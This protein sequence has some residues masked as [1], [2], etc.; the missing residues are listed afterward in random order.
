M[1][2]EDCQHFA[3]MILQSQ[4]RIQWAASAMAVKG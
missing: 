3:V 1:N 4:V 2:L